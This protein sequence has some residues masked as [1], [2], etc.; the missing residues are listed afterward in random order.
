MHHAALKSDYKFKYS[1]CQEMVQ[2]GSHSHLGVLGEKALRELAHA[3]NI[4]FER[5]EAVLT[6]THN[7]CF[8]AKIRNN[9]YTPAYPSFAI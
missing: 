2:S 4:I 5:G 6:N 8:G 1:I 9:R 3:I 7:L